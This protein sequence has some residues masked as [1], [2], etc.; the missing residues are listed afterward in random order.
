MGSS[1]EERDLIA[2]AVNA[3]SVAAQEEVLRYA[4]RFKR[5]EE[6]RPLEELAER[7]QRA[8]VVAAFE[9]VQTDEEKV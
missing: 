4:L 7:V 6:Y 8:V 9:I 1:E 3:A 5:R 2:R